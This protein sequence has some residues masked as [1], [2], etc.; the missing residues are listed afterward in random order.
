MS[1][2]YKVFTID[3]DDGAAMRSVHAMKELMKR[4]IEAQDLVL[5]NETAANTRVDLP[6]DWDIVLQERPPETQEE[7]TE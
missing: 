6:D 4:I 2:D 7:A 1:R 3:K 5:K